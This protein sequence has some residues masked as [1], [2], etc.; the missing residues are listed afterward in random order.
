MIAPNRLL[1]VGNDPDFVQLVSSQL[2]KHLD[3]PPLM[4]RYD[5]VGQHLGPGTDGLILLL[6]NQ[7][8]DVPGV[9]EV[10]QEVQILQY[11]P[12]MMLV[13]TTTAGID[14]SLDGFQARLNERRPWAENSK[15]F[16]ASLEHHA[17]ANQGLGF[18]DPARE[19]IRA[20]T[21]AGFAHARC[22]R[23]PSNWL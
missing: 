16:I 21:G 1:L 2:G 19:S 22:S 13:E 9:K 17:N 10:L 15:D 20:S 5:A 11:N 4:C 12:R 14:G 6:A 18:F 3:Q 7:P 8:A 23:W